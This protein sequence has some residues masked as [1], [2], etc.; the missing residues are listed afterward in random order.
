METNARSILLQPER[1]L[2]GILPLRHWLSEDSANGFERGQARTRLICTAIALLGFLIAAHFSQLPEGIVSVAI[3]Y[4]LFAISWA[5][6]GRVHPKPTRWKRGC[7]ILM[8][9]LALTYIASFGGIF[10]TYVGFLFLTT[11]GWGLRFGRHY[12]FLATGIAILGML[13]NLAATPFWQEHVLF[14]ATIIFGLAA[15]ALNAATLLGRIARGNRDLA[16]KMEEIE[17]VAWQDQLTRLPNRLYFHERLSQVLASAERNKRKV[18][19]LLFDIDGF[20]TVNDTLGHEAGDRLL[21]EI[22]ERVGSRTRQADTFARIGGDEFVVLMELQ[23][24]E[25]DAI[26]VAEA[27]MSAVGEI[28][29]FDAHGLR[30]GASIG[31][32]CS[33][34]GSERERIADEMLIKADHAMYDA[35]R[36]GKGR[37][38]FAGRAD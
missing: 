9:H 29:M 17:K 7:A 22:A 1:V 19:L 38:Q 35:K 25:S 27:V 4:A 12:L 3:V 23:R 28:D 31:I 26:P 13:W 20:K 2:E 32:S 18:A 37:Y 24:D 11:V 30:V 8:D 36:A 6:L 21:K 33:D 14:G 5:I 15:S 34:L 16:G 10:A